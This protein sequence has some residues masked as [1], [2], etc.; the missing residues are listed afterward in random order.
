[1]AIALILIFAT[2]AWAI[3]VRKRIFLLGGSD[4]IGE[5][6]W[7]PSNM[8]SGGTPSQKDTRVGDYGAEKACDGLVYGDAGNFAEGGTEYYGGWWWKY[9]LGAGN[10]KVFTWCGLYGGTYG[11]KNFKVEGSNNDSDWTV[12]HTDIGGYTYS[13]T[14]YKMTN[15]TAYRYYR[16]WCIDGYDPTANVPKVPEV[17]LSN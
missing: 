4:T 9:D 3:P 16:F 1:M 11:M 14:Y 2:T 13:W 7:P 6:S 15:S 10:A 8:I 5:S 17:L 12:I